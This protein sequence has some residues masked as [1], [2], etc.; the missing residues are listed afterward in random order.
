MITTNHDSYDIQWIVDQARCVFD[1]RNATLGT[2]RA[3][4]KVFKL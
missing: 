1:T 2:E 3:V 4:G